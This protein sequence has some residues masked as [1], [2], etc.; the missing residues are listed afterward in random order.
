MFGS[1]REKLHL[2]VYKAVIVQKIGT[3]EIKTCVTYKMNFRTKQ[4]KR[5][6][7]ELES[8][9]SVPRYRVLKV[10]YVNPSKQWFKHRVGGFLSRSAVTKH[11]PIDFTYEAY[12]HAQKHVIFVDWDTGA[13]V[14]IGGEIQFAYPPEE[15]A[16]KSSLMRSVGDLMRGKSDLVMILMALGLG[17]FL[18]MF[19]Q[20]TLIPL[21]GGF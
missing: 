6:V 17:V 12:S 20:N 21:L 1:L 5:V 9:V 14:N 8:P 13:S 7:S 11:L 19:I 2:A 10:K 4:V 3:S 16:V 15:E 18:G